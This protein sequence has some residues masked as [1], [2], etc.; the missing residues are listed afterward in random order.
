MKIYI[1]ICIFGDENETFLCIDLNNLKVYKD[2]SNKGL[3]NN[4]K[5][6]ENI[7]IELF[8]LCKTGKVIVSGGGDGVGPHSSQI[9]LGQ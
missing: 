4:N 3:S 5:I 8:F 1:Y 2:T 6:N 9:F 7:D